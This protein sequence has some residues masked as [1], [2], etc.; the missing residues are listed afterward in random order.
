MSALLATLI[1]GVVLLCALLRRRVRRPSAWGEHLGDAF[2]RA[3]GVEP[4]DPWGSR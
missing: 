3:A 1:A 2:D 4:R